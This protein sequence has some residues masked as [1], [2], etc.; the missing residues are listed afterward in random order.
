MSI[1]GNSNRCGADAGVVVTAGFATVPGF[2]T[3]ALSGRAV[4]ANGQ[5]VGVDLQRG[6]RDDAL[7]SVGH[8]VGVWPEEMLHLTQSRYQ[9]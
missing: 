2:A 7:V 3:K 4:P 9:R 1:L 6:H 5:A 8:I